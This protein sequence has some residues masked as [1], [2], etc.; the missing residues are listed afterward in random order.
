MSRSS[1]ITTF[2]LIA[3]FGYIALVINSKYW[4]NTTASSYDVGIGQDDY[5]YPEGWEYLPISTSNYLWRNKTENATIYYEDII[6]NMR[7]FTD[8]EWMHGTWHWLIE[9]YV[10]EIGFNGFIDAISQGDIPSYAQ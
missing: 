6:D 7:N 2:F 10:P 9:R 1:V 3:T 4:S 8:A 5:F